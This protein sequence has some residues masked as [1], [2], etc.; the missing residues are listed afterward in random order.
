MQAPDRTSRPG[1]ESRRRESTTTGHELPI[2]NPNSNANRDESTGDYRSTASGGSGRERIGN[3]VIG[4]EIGRGSFATVYK[5]YRSVS[6]LRK[7]GHT[8]PFDTSRRGSICRG[9]ADSHYD[10]QFDCSTSAA[11]ETTHRHQSR[12][13]I[14]A[15]G[16][17]DGEPRGRDF[18]PQGDQSSTHRRAGGLYRECHGY[19]QRG[20]GGAGEVL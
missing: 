11:V 3:Y 4:N 2:P 7:I 20:A 1:R 17:V 8:V 18:H 14:Q 9:Q 15:H 16:K 6:L 19:D 10:S 5:G 12:L 13:Q